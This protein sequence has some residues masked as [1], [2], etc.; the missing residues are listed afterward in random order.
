VVTNKF[1]PVPTYTPK[2]AFRL[3][4]LYTV[5]DIFIIPKSLLDNEVLSPFHRWK[6]G[7]QTHIV[8]NSTPLPLEP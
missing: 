8:P 6:A 3:C 5:F 2:P 4:L 1:P 7:A